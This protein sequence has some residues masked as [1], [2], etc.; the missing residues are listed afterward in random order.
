MSGNAMPEK[1]ALDGAGQRSG[2]K[3]PSRLPLVQVRSVLLGED[4]PTGKAGR[5]GCGWERLVAICDP[6]AGAGGMAACQAA[7]RR[8]LEE[9]PEEL[10]GRSGLGDRDESSG[11]WVSCACFNVWRKHS[12]DTTAEYVGGAFCRHKG[13]LPPCE[14]LCRETLQDG[15]VLDEVDVGAERGP[16]DK[17][18]ESD[19]HDSRVPEGDDQQRSIARDEHQ[20]ALADS[21]GDA[22]RNTAVSLLNWIKTCIREDGGVR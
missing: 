5:M 15:G 18:G 19:P 7:A 2:G 16:E 14:R 8:L 17:R 20:R 6:Y 1:S 22:G 13:G 21:D 11:Y 9:A 3:V 12:E 4:R 10:C